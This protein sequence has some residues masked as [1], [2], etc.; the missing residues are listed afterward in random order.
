MFE[1]N[2]WRENPLGSWQDIKLHSP[3]R[4]QAALAQG[5]FCSFNDQEKSLSVV[6]KALNPN[7]FTGGTKPTNS[8]GIVN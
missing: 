1:N 2:A 8:Y 5:A 3:N 4:Y 6:I 7:S